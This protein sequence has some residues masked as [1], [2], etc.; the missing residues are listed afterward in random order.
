MI[1]SQS[2][3]METSSSPSSRF[4]FHGLVGILLMS[5][6]WVINWSLTGSRTHYLF[7]ALWLGYCLTI[8][9]LTV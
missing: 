7:F 3:E 9:G 8:D 6:M 1:V 2:T 4:P 5:T